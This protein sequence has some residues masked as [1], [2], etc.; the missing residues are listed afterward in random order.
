MMTKIT[1]TLV[2]LCFDLVRFGTIDIYLTLTF[3]LIISSF[4]GSGKEYYLKGKKEENAG[5]RHF[6]LFKQCFLPCEKHILSANAINL[7]KSKNSYKDSNLLPD[8]G[9]Y[10]Q[11]DVPWKQAF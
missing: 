11:T 9:M 7:N 10:H 6:L 5:Y 3:N 2:L 1:V 8:G 4:K